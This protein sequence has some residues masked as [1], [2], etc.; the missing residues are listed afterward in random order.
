MG[1]P[2]SG[3]G[4]DKISNKS[5]DAIVFNYFSDERCKFVRTG[6]GLDGPVSRA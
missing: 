2:K 3:T 4:D 6:E 5:Q 1:L